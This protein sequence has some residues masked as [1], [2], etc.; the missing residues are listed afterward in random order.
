MTR[1]CRALYHRAE[2][3]KDKELWKCAG[4]PQ[5]F[6]RPTHVCEKTTQEAPERI[7]DYT[8]QSC[9]RQGMAPPVPTNE[10]GNLIINS[11]S[12]KDL[13]GFCLSRLAKD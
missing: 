3:R 13:R 7:W 10:S 2:S 12:D 11:T 9:Y 6:S 4:V 1:V 5:V 8:P